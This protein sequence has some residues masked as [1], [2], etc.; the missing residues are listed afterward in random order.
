MSRYHIPPR[1]VEKLAAAES[2]AALTGAGVSAE[3]GVPTFRDAMTG[4]WEQFRAEDLATPEAFRRDPQLVWDW[5]QWRR[6]LVSEVEPNPGHVAL[7]AMQNRF[8][9]FSLIT[10]NVDD[11]HQRAGSR[12]VISLHGSLSETRCFACGLVAES[13]HTESSPP[14]CA[15][16]GGWLRPGVVWF[17]EALPPAALESAMLASAECDVFLCIGTS[18]L[19]YPAAGLPQLALENGATVVE[20]NSQETPLSADADFFLQGPS[21]KILPQ[22][23]EEIHPS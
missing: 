20:I 23:L 22:L 6:C 10:Q 18:G 1:L 15:E 8:R 3:S 11:L 7:A 14:K 16:C 9:K 12:D 4:L 19:V 21:G 17:G 2:V 13:F 5:Y